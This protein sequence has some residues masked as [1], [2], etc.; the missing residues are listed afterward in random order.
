MTTSQKMLD[1]E[2]SLFER[3]AAGL[4]IRHGIERCRGGLLSR[5]EQN[6]R[7]AGRKRLGICASPA[8]GR[9]GYLFA[10]DT[11]SFGAGGDDAW[12]STT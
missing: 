3:S 5:L 2:K 7:R 1:E 12:V 9:R 8:T 4:R 10:G 6:L 11:S